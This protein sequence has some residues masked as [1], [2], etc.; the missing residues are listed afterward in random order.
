MTF[1]EIDSS[2]IIMNEQD[3]MQK[4]EGMLD[5]GVTEEQMSNG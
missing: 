5:E 4:L 2:A 3:Y 1:Q